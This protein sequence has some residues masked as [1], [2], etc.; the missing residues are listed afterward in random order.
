MLLLTENQLLSFNLDGQD[1]F[2]LPH[3]THVT[4]DGNT[5][6]RVYTF[7]NGLK[8]TQY[9]KKYADFGAYEWR[10]TFENIGKHFAGTTSENN[11]SHR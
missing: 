4:C 2:S 8:V 11:P 5:M 7:Q 10:Q 1:A 6:T 9:A 3:E